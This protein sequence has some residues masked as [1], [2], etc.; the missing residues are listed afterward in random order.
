MR[1]G[2]SGECGSALAGDREPRCEMENHSLERP[3][4]CG[5]ESSLQGQRGRWENRLEVTVRSMSD[6]GK[7][8]S[9]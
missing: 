4:G 9:G 5:V 8:Q 6:V 3:C 2:C 7:E 1:T